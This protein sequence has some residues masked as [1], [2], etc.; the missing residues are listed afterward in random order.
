[1]KQ[2]HICCSKECVGKLRETIYLGKDNPN[3]GNTGSKNP[4]WKSDEKISYYGY[5]LI[6]CP[7]HPFKNIDGF[8]FEH[9]LVAEK[10]LL[11]EENSVEINGIR[12]LSPQYLVHHKD[13]NKLNNTPEN[14]LILTPSDHMRLHRKDR[15]NCH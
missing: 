5:K 1:M 10:Y 3:Y 11:T 2:Q 12:Y 7:E 13:H 9:R 14:L 8:V 15:K 4:M 6:R